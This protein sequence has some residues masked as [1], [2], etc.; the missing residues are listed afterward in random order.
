MWQ[1]K[2]QYWKKPP[3]SWT[4]MMS[5]FLMGTLSCNRPFFWN[6]YVYFFYVL[7]F[8]LSEGNISNYRTALISSGSESAIP[9]SGTIVKTTSRLQPQQRE[10]SRH[11][12]LVVCFTYYPTSQLLLVPSPLNLLSR[13]PSTPCCVV[14]L[15]QLLVL[16]PSLQPAEITTIEIWH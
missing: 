8:R 11:V 1:S 10:L 12:F 5:K 7:L 6:F 9:G 14:Y 16:V 4:Y 15:F 13:C 3:Q 2:I